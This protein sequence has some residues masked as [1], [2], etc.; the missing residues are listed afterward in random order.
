MKSFADLHIHSCISPCADN[1]MTPNN[2]LGMASLKGLEYIAITDH[3]TCANLPA[4][5]KLQDEYG[6]K[7]IPGIEITTS[8]EVHILAYFKNIEAA[9]LCGKEVESK[10]PKIKNKKDLFGDQLILDE[11]DNI[12]SECD[13][14]LIGS[15]SLNIF[16]VYD[17]VQSYDA[18][19]VPAHINRGNNGLLVNQGIIPFGLDIK[20]IEYYR[21]LPIESEYLN[22]YRHTF[23]SD[24]HYLG[25][26]LEK[27]FSFDFKIDNMTD[28]INWLKGE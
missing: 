1:E 21:S 15:T 2:I 7:V 28:I 19:F 14:L 9:T 5:F 10:L 26:I 8:E 16:D 13:S 20:V 6:V 22:R 24:A 4:F 27:E 23:S 11:D 17:L 3:N 12:I 25:N 18:A